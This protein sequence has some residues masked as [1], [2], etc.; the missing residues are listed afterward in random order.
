[1]SL[2]T[3]SPISNGDALDA[4]P[5]NQNFTTV[6][7]AIN[8][9]LDDS[10]VK[11]GANIATSKLAAESWTAFTPAPTGFT[12]AVTVT[13]ARYYQIGK[14]VF[15][16]IDFYGTSNSTTTGFTLPVI[17][18]STTSALG[19]NCRIIDNGSSPDYPG[20]ISISAGS[21]AAGAIAGISG[22]HFWTNSGIKGVQAHFFY[23][24]Q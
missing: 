21:A 4:T 12:G 2:I 1:M 23:E 24:A 13:L 8:G 15:V 7:T 10:N 22:G 14:L 16:D 3:L 6:A 5:V 17:P 11:S 19:G 9:Q 18:K 20:S